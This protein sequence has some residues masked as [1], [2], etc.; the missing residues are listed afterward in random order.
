[1]PRVGGPLLL[2]SSSSR[3]MAWSAAAAGY[4][5]ISMDCF[6]DL[7]TVAAS[8][9]AIKLSQYDP[10]H[11]LY[12]LR[13]MYPEYRHGRL[14][15][16]G[17]L[18]ND[19]YL[20]AKLGLRSSWLGPRLDLRS[21]IGDS[22]KLYSMLG[23]LG[24][25]M[26]QTMLEAP[27]PVV[28]GQTWLY[29][30]RYG[31]GGLGITKHFINSQLSKNTNNSYCW[32]Q[33]VC[34][35]SWSALFLAC[36]KKI[37]ILGFNRHLPSL[38]EGRGYC[39]RGAISASPLAAWKRQLSQ[40]L[41]AIVRDSGLVGLAG[42]DFIVDHKDCQSLKIIEINPRPTATMALHHRMPG[43]L[44]LHIEACLGESPDCSSQ[45][46][47]G[48]KGEMVYYAKRSLCVGA[49]SLSWPSWVADR[50]RSGAVFL[51]GEPV[52]TIC[53]SGHTPDDVQAKLDLRFK[54]LTTLINKFK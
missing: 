37:E 54:L 39:Y 50:P 31:S 16:G 36:R 24:I 48:S 8:S 47:M 2:L 13:H 10:E 5:A 3:R 49:E 22:I 19:D 40:Y 28:G 29:K 41:A 33:Y 45:D 23:R 53:A 18:E 17:G 30:P 9:H 14:I 1:M 26:P 21:E 7:D 44:A 51:P 32:Q 34:G 12:M 46:G 6:A 15:V 43:L 25:A 11:S 38:W 35:E 42:V 52:C 27:Q 20:V 4:S